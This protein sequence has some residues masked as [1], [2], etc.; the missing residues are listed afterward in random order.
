MF[1]A[2]EK[3]LDPSDDHN[4]D[5]K[6]IKETWVENVYHINP[7]QFYD[8]GVFLDLGANI[9]AVSLYVDNFNK[10]RASDLPVIKTY[11]VEP[12]PSNLILLET[13]I[14]NNPTT[15]NI[16]VIKGAVHHELKEVEISDRG[17]NASIYKHPNAFKYTKVPALSIEELFNKYNIKEADV[18][19][20]DIEGYERQLII[21]T[22]DDILKRIKF[23]TL[24]F[25]ATT[26]PSFGI[27]VQK[28]A[29]IYGI[30]ILGVPERGGYLYCARY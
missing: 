15:K 27:M 22:P 1:E 14:A 9:G 10:D 29:G 16:T 13:N 2:R 6:V 28:L 23:L 3:R 26:D 12:E 25:D 7:D 4:L 11:A 5:Y 8:T 30:Q 24:E 17:G 21:N 18:C 20:I 19:K